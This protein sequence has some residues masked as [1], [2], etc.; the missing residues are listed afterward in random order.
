[1]YQRRILRTRSSPNQYSPF[2]FYKTITKI[3]S[4]MKSA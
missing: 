3:N 2:C 4:G 1:M